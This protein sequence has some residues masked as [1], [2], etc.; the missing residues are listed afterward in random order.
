MVTARNGNGGEERIWKIILLFLTAL[1]VVTAALTGAIYN[2]VMVVL[3]RHDSSL[4]ELKAC[5]ESS[6]AVMKNL[7]DTDNRVYEEIR[8]IKDEFKEIRAERRK[9]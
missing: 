8:Q 2:R 9:P 7:S 5:A 4:I 1:A 6:K 3:D